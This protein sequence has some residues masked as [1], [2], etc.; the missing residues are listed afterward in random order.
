MKALLSSIGSRGDVQ[1]LLAVALELRKLGHDPRLCVAPNF[2][3]WVESFGLTCIPIGPDLKTITA[4][5]SSSAPP[6]LSAEQRRQL[7]AHAVR[8]QLPVLTE[9]A[10]GCDLVVAAGALQIATRSVTE[11]L[12][13]R[14]VF[15]AYCPAVL[16]SQDHPP[17]KMDEHYP[18][19]LPASANLSLWEEE[20]Q[21][22]NDLFRAALNEERAKM[23]LAPVESVQRHIFTNSPWLAADPAIAP[24]GTSTALQIVQTGAWLMPEQSAL[25]AHVEHFLASGAPPVYIGFGS[26]RASEQTSSVLIEA[27]RTLGLRSIIS[28]G[29]GNLMPIDSGIDCL[30]IDEVAHDK[31]FPRVAA[32][33]HHGGAGTTTTAARAGRSQVIVPH[34]YDQYY[35]AHR[36]SELGIGVSGPA[37]ENF[38]TD[39]IVAALRECLQPAT[40]GRALDSA[41]RVHVSG[42]RI[43]AERLNAL[44]DNRNSSHEPT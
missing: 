22:W 8:T 37:R 41:R 14:Y 23:R 17:P 15:A 26:M 24:A 38:T 33:V 12:K 35:W 18:Q 28:Q 21:N 30:A 6:R 43:A 13:I 16:P 40:T 19:S 11:A 39:D 31:L 44:L 29:W 20:E 10:R 27:A 36:V 1:P 4:R 7:A 25:P 32:V 34:L 5:A 2:K 9:A 3:E 42:A